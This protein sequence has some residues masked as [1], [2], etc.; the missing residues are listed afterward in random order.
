MLLVILFSKGAR[1]E[2]I[3]NSIFLKIQEYRKT[4]EGSTAR[5]ENVPQASVLLLL[6]HC[7]GTQEQHHWQLAR[8]RDLQLYVVSVGRNAL[9]VLNGV[10][11]FSV[12]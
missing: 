3:G 9:Y 2:L 5:G 12:V 1:V 7:S 6:P 8:V 10:T 4:K 11:V